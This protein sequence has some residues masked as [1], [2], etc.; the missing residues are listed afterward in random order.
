[1][2]SSCVSFAATASSPTAREPLTSTTSPGRTSSREGARS[3]R[4][5]SRPDVTSTPSSVAPRRAGRP[6]SARPRRQPR[7]PRRS[8]GDRRPHR[9]RALPSRPSTAMRRRGPAALGQMLERRAHR[10][11]VRV[12]AVVD[13]DDPPGSSST[14]SRSGAKSTSRRPSVERDPEQLADGQRRE[15]VVELVAGREARLEPDRA[16]ADLEAALPL[17]PG[18][19]A[20]SRCRCGRG[21]A[22]AAVRR[23]RPRRRRA[24]APSISSA[25]AR[26]TFS[27]VPTSS[28]W[29]GAIFVISPISGR[30]NAASQAIW[31]SPRMPISTMQTSVSGSMRQSVSGTP[32][33]LL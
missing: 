14:S 6:R 19:S 9:R 31:P 26:A 15:R 16:T 13:Q 30:A 18:R 8:P 11:G 29:T 5:R 10:D 17:R 12:V 7:P 1:M 4:L 28:R 23:A 33:S 3:P 20:E 32:S 27:T 25:L 21:R 2:P 22:R 24:A